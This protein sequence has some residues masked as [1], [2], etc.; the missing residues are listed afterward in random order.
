MKI[1][2]IQISAE[3]KEAQKQLE[4]INLTLEQQEDLLND[5]QRKI[6]SIEDLRDKTSPKDLNR[7]K[8][9]NEK[10]KEQ[11]KFLKRTK[12]RITEQRQA[13]TKENKVVKESI[14]QQRDY[15]GVLGIIDKQTGGLISGFQGFGKSIGGATKGLK[16]MRVA[17]IA[18]G[19]GAFVVLVT[20]LVAAF[21]RS[22]EGQE[23]LQVGL[24]MLGAV[25]NQV[26]D[27]F[28][29]LGRGHN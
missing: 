17:F 7:I 8:E 20:S 14:K 15:G 28:A 16:L 21:S 19:I 6:E 9:Y 26:M 11:E 27:S 23:K 22:E 25:V 29:S 18:T 2:A 4:K 5:I 24:K 13:R 10:I 1:K 3:T 12:T